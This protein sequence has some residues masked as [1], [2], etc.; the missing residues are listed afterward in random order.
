MSDKAVLTCA[1]TGVL[2]NPRQHP[3]PVTPAQMAAEARAA[4]DAGASIMHV[5]LRRQ[6]EGMGHLP[7]W[8]PEVADA[9]VGAIRN[10]CPGVIINLT[11]GVI[12][13]D[14]SGPVACIR[15]VRPEIAA[16]NAGSLNYLKLKDDGTWAWPPMVFDNPVT[17]VQ[18]FL[19]VMHECGV[20]PEFECFDVG[21]VRCVGM[22]VKS[23]MFRP[24]MGRPDY[25]F[26]MGVASGMPCDA[27]LLQLLPGYLAQGA[28]WQATLIGRRE[29]WPVHEAAAQLGGMLRTG[30]EDTFYLPNGERARGN[31]EL[32]EALAQ[33]ARRAGREVAST[34]EARALLGLAH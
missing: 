21:I 16:C 19:D 31:G 33:C 25:N 10:A 1:L 22:F 29:I 27:S 34:G 32:I 14:I 30:L 2:T 15:R 28:L 9:V 12:G 18:Q 3:V 13:P 7:S 26:V 5:H 17:K 8:D 23:G 11:T 20:R 4:F 24:T 6:E